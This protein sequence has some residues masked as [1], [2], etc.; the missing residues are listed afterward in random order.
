VANECPAS[1]T[2]CWST[3]FIA[4]PGRRV[5]KLLC[6]AHHIFCLALVVCSLD[7]A[8]GIGLACYGATIGLVLLALRMT[9]DRA[10][11]LTSVINPRGRKSN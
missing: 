11:R 4:R 5:L 10:P 2:R 8:I 3:A 1:A 7:L 9:H 6:D